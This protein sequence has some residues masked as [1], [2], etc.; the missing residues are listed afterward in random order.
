MRKLVSASM[1]AADKSKLIDELKRLEQNDVDLVHFD[2]MDNVFVNNTSFM[3]D[4]FFKIRK[5]TTLPFE[6]HLMVHNPI[7]YLDKY[8]YSSDDV[9]IVHYEL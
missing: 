1:L 2:V 4:T 8:D 7:D 6:I 5:Y 3:D 9:I